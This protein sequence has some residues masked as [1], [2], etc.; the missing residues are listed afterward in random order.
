MAL[1]VSEVISDVDLFNKFEFLSLS[2]KLNR[3]FYSCLRGVL[4]FEW[5]RAWR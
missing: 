5:Q 4:A 2:N 3:Q 1:V